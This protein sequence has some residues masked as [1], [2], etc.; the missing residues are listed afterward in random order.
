MSRTIDGT[1]A[2]AG[3]AAIP[4]TYQ[5]FTSGS[6][7]Y[8]PPAGV[9]YLIVEMVGGGAG[10]GQGIYSTPVWG[11]NA[12]NYLKVRF[13]SGTYSYAVGSGGGGAGS[14]GTNGTAGGNTTFSTLSATGGAAGQWEITASNGANTASTT[15]GALQIFVDRPG[16]I[17]HN[18]GSN[19]GQVNSGG[20]SYWS[21]NTPVVS[22]NNQ[23]VY[24]NA[25]GYGGGGA[26]VASGVTGGA[27]SGSG[28]RIIVTEIY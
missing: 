18:G 20:A 22:F 9:S 5:V 23:S 24:K 10:G 15:T 1:T 12:G 4:P 3:A 17:G 26:G 8:K 11:G 16:G 7:T 6:G 27:G 14:P 28:G 13:A 2:G 19:I 25:S 21:P